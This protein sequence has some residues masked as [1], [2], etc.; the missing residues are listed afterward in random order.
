MGLF[1]NCVPKKRMEGVPVFF[2]GKFAHADAD[3]HFL[4]GEFALADANAEFRKVKY[5]WVL[6]KSCLLYNELVN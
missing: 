6:Y 1:I 4:L 2:L 5:K 3:A